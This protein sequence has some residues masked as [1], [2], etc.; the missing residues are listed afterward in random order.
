MSR[1]S[2]RCTWII[3]LCVFLLAAFIFVSWGS[4]G[5]RQWDTSKWFNYWWQGKPAKVV[6]VVDQP[7]E[8]KA[9]ALQSSNG[10]TYDSDETTYD[11]V[12]YG[13]PQ[14]A[15]SYIDDDCKLLVS[16]YH[17]S[18]YAHGHKMKIEV[19]T[20]SDTVIQSFEHTFSDIA[21]SYSN[22]SCNH[23]SF[24]VS[25]SQMKSFTTD[26]CIKVRAWNV[27]D[28]SG[29]E[30]DVIT[31]VVYLG[32][33][34][35]SFTGTVLTIPKVNIGDYS[36]PFHIV[37]VDSGLSFLSLSDA[38][39]IT[40]DGNFSLSMGQFHYAHLN[41]NSAAFTETA[42][43]YIV[44]L[45]DLSFATQINDVNSVYVTFV[46]SNGINDSAAIYNGVQVDFVLLPLTPFHFSISQLAAPQNISLVN[47]KLAWNEVEGAHGYGIFE[48]DNYWMVNET[49]FDLSDKDFAAGE[50]TIRIRA[51]GNVGQSLA[52]TNNGVM[53]S[54]Y[55][56]AV[57]ITQLVA[58]T[59]SI[60]GDSIT[61]FVPQGSKM[62]G[63]TYEVK[64]SGKEFGGWYYDEGFS[65]PVVSTDVIND[66]ITI[67][68]R[69]SDKKVTE[70]QLTWWEL[71][72][73]QVLIPIFVFAGLL[74][75]GLLVFV[76]RRKK[77]A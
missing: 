60:N 41:S 31:K 69:L 53:V 12:K 34:T 42:T 57:N 50:H 8:Q 58:L 16:S 5:F 70:R 30:S 26:D 51:L 25:V 46:N 40:V 77:S 20:L 65:R 6:N 71:H 9:M 36:I 29:L 49:E 61:K 62:S 33:Y 56:A 32:D 35:Y 22:G 37:A 4:E 19:L 39:D 55:N 45:E 17:Y 14:V 21:P 38:H 64:V 28:S 23:G 63:Y 66:D 2:R 73:W 18:K 15:V 76:I 3:V 48:G 52:A 44:H 47:G 1:L 72:K 24:S 43:N 74:V 59:Y 67:Y 27:G 75:M 11:L 7:A 10:L 68:A 13:V 54:A